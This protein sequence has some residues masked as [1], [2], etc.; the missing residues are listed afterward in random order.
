MRKSNIKILLTIAAT[1][2]WDIKTSDVT[3][4]FLQSVP[5]EREVLVKPPKERRVPGTIWRLKRTAYGLGDASRGFY[6]SFS[7]KLSEFGCEKS[8][9][10]PAMFLFF[11]KE[12]TREDEIRRPSGIAVTHVDDVLHAGND[13]FE[14]KVM[15]PL[16]DSFKFGT[17]EEIEFRYVGLHMK[18]SSSG[19]S[20]DQD[21][22]VNNLEEPTMNGVKNLKVTDVLSET[23]QT[24]FRSAVAKL[25]T[26]AYTSRPDLCFEVKS[27]SSKYG[28][29]TKSDLRSIHRKIVLLKA[30]CCT[31][32]AYPK[33]GNIDDWVLVGHG[34]AGIKSMPD[35]MTSVG[36]GV[37]LLCNRKTGAAT[38]LS[39]RSKKLRRKVTSSL[40]GE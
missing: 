15:K 28:K 38:A 20:V 11:D 24:E 31:S 10:D 35:K 22:Y 30:D 18:Q 2:E 40:A 12:V 14:K 3:A 29:A 7:G 27:L 4:A 13:M 23:D 8:L 26:I 17:E 33:M 9:L 32:L 5:I 36:G 19:I 39:W 1:E 6:L 25:S 21:H 16:K 37:L 34:D